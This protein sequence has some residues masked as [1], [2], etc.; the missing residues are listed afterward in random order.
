MCGK[1][2]VEVSAR[3]L[4]GRVSR[5]GGRWLLPKCVGEKPIW[6]GVWPYLDPMDS[7]CLRT[8]S[9][10]WNVPGKFRPHGV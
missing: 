8:A 9:M 10:E 1:F 7:V 4:V 3:V 6:E 2:V 5:N